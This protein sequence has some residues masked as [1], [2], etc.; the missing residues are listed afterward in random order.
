MQKNQV[1]IQLKETCQLTGAI[2]AIWLEH[3]SDWEILAFYKLNAQIRSTLMQYIKDG[4][5]RGLV[6]RSINWQTQP[7]AFNF[8]VERAS[9][10]QA[11]RFPRPDDTKGDLS[12]GG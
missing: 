4:G 2:W 7:I 1:D 3:S 9:R 12:W 8:A 5:S 6:E 10:H 11:L